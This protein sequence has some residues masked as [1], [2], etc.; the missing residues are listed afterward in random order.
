MTI[1]EFIMGMPITITIQDAG[2]EKKDFD[3]IFDYFRSIDEQFSTYKDTSEVTRINRGLLRIEATSDSMKEIITQ[4]QLTKT[5]SKGYFNCFHKNT[6][7]PSGIVKGWS[8]YQAAIQLQKA[9]FKHYFIDAGGDVQV[10]EKNKEGKPW[11]V[12]IRNPFNGKEIIKVLSV[13]NKGVA[14]S[15]TAARGQHIYNPHQPGQEI[16]D[17]VSITVVGKNVYEADRF[18]TAAFAMGKSGIEFVESLPDIEGYMVDA[19][20]TATF[21]NHF[22]Q[23]V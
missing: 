18:A 21:T 11:K 23:Y 12:G 5:E 22:S 6:F 3:I 16:K 7:D 1:T 9:G 14:T 19:K 10:S 4:C 8:I 13:S 15:G 2:V 20:G 17:I